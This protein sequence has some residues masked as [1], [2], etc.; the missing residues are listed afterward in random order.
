MIIIQCDMVGF[1]ELSRDLFLT[2]TG[3]GSSLGPSLHL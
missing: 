1:P 3:I 2:Q